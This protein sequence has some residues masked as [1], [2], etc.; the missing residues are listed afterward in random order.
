M[1]SFQSMV[2]RGLLAIGFCIPAGGHAVAQVPFVPPE[3]YNSIRPDFG[4]RLPLCILPESATARQDRE[5]AHEIAQMLLLEPEIVEIDADMGMLDELGIW[6]VIFEELAQSCL[7]VMGV[8]II[9][10]E[11]T[12]DWMT[13]SGPYFEAP[14]V[15]IST[16]PDVESLADLPEGAR[17]G[18]PLFTPIDA[19][20]MMTIESGA[21]GGVRRLPYD[22]PGLMASLMRD[23]ELD[24]AI[25]WAPH[26][27]QSSLQPL[28]F[29]KGQ[30]SVAPLRQDTRAV[31]VL[32]R[33]QDQMLR[34]MIDQAIGALETGAER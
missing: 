19:E 8:Q 30:G 11:V 16:D 14:Y 13:L 21:L 20:V 25:V 22:R 10:G 4:N 5:A 7:G 15:L 12:P 17:L 26:L 6:P 27:E 34:T 3:F 24:A 23:G 9:P 29:F 33:E 2:L 32:M 31:A 1:T 18:V 28:D